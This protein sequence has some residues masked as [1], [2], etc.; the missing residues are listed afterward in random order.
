MIF[1]FNMPRKEDI[2]DEEREGFEESPYLRRQRAIE[3]KRKRLEFNK[4]TLFFRVLLGVILLAG[5]LLG[6]RRFAEY[7]TTSAHFQIQIHNI[8]GLR[9]LSERVVMQELEPLKGQN[10]FTANYKDRMQALLRIPWVESVVFLRFWPATLSVIITERTPVGYALI[11]GVVELVD[12]EGIPLTRRGDTQQSFDFPIMRGLAPENTT[13]DHV[14]NRIRIDHYVDL[15]KELDSEQSGYS[16]D[17][18]EVDVSDVDDVR[19]ILKDDSVLV[20]L[21]KDSYLSRFKVYLANIK[22]LKQEYPDIDSVDMRFKGQI[23]VKRQE[24]K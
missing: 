3:V 14:I 24:K 23:V 6:A 20:H 7:V 2:L 8:N 9:N 5:I 1:R 22:R 13:D 21:G 10:I 17:L 18:S 15:L 12:R 16:K 19:V 11:N 4:L